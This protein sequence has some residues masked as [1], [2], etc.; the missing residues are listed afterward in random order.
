M[1]DELITIEFSGVQADSLVRC[2]HEVERAWGAC[3]PRRMER[4]SVPDADV[5]CVVGYA[6]D[7]DARAMAVRTVVAAVSRDVTRVL[8]DRRRRYDLLLHAAAFRP[9]RSSDCIAV[10]G[11]SGA[12]KTTFALAQRQSGYL[13]DELVAVDSTGVVTPY[14]KP[15]S[16]VTRDRVKDQRVPS[17][18][19]TTPRRLGA[20]ILLDRGPA[21][22]PTTAARLGLVESMT[23]L[24]PHTSGIS[25]L[26][27]PLHRLARAVAACGG[28]I[29]LRYSDADQVDLRAVLDHCP[30]RPLGF[31]DVLD[32]DAVVL[33]GASTL[34]R[35][36]YA[37]AIEAEGHLILLVRDR[38]LCLS[39][40]A[41][42]IWRRSARDAAAEIAPLARVPSSEEDAIVAALTDNGALLRRRAV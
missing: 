27:R 31:R 30:M 18:P 6:T 8:V 35:A 19:D 14:P 23:A 1:G 4:G 41:A 21:G 11:A 39:P 28:A 9:A 38:L 17:R 25:S 24:L 22:T 26:P 32:N 2:V 34:V 10:V 29:R 12:G 33:G 15:L 7:T 16:I 37:D 42:A 3:R 40:A 20:L 5:R 36:P 13:T